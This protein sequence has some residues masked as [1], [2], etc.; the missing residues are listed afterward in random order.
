MRALEKTIK[1]LLVRFIFEM[2][3]KLCVLLSASD[4]TQ[5]ILPS[6]GWG[7]IGVM[8]GLSAAGGHALALRDDCPIESRENA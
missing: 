4:L 3:H 5:F 2:H 6:N 8:A 1:V 7:L